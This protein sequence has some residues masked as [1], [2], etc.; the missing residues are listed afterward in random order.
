MAV[1][2]TQSPSIFI[3]ILT[4]KAVIKGDNAIYDCLYVWI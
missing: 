3:H 2:V 4:E 1:A